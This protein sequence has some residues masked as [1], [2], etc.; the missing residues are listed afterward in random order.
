M[1]SLV[2][3]S[4]RELAQTICACTEGVV[5]SSNIRVTNQFVSKKVWESLPKRVIAPYA[6]IEYLPLGS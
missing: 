1:I 5:G 3:A 2:V 6:K 4:E